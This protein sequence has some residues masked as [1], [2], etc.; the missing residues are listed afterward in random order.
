MFR[1]CSI[2]STFQSSDADSPKKQMTFRPET[3][4]SDLTSMDGGQIS[5]M[6]RS[7][8]G[9]EN[10][11]MHNSDDVPCGTISPYWPSV[12]SQI[13]HHGDIDSNYGC[14]DTASVSEMHDAVHHD[15]W[16]GGGGVVT[17]ERCMSCISKLGAMSRSSTVTA[18]MTPGAGS[19]FHPAWTMESVKEKSTDRNSL[20]SRNSSGGS[21][22]YSIPR[23]I[24]VNPSSNQDKLPTPSSPPLK[25]LD[26]PQ[27]LPPSCN[28]PNC[29]PARPPKLLPLG[30]S[31]VNSQC[32]NKVKK[33]PMPLPI[34]PVICACQHKQAA[35]QQQNSGSKVG[36]YENYDV[37][38]LHF[39][40]VS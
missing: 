36:P 9:D 1:L 8:Y 40:E 19:H 13:C 21:T 39:Q 37:P 29:P 4:L 32:S 15:S 16:P 23:F 3:R 31:N 24:N 33:P 12:E 5:D 7:A 38:K 34:E 22:E 17:L 28:C 27:P 35:E 18:A 30:N 2:T 14:G 26:A 6:N 10:C 11:C 20:S 25:K